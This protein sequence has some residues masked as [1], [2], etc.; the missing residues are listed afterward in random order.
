MTHP[1][2]ATPF[3]PEHAPMSILEDLWRRASATTPVPDASTLLAIASVALALVIVAW[4]QVRMLVTVCH[5]AGHAV[6]ATLTGRSIDG[7]R[8]HS[9]TSGVTLTRGRPTGVGMVVTL[10]G[11][12]P[13]AS[14]VGLLGAAIAG[15]GY[16]VGMLW[17]LVGLLVVMLLKI[18]NVH[19]ALVVLALAAVLALAS[20]YAPAHILVWLAYGLA[21]LLLLAGPRP[22]LELGLARR[23]ATT[24]SDAAQLARLTHVPRL[25]WIVVWLA[26]T[27]GA[28]AWGTVLMLPG[29]LPSVR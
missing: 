15:A 18:R 27:L 6:A 14:L 5:E 24:A 21:W 12:Y 9:D 26:G 16:A 3:T 19:G 28:L 8:L 10:L 7:I 11:G 22:V 1:S 2:P 17:L 4:S 20:W 25:V 29:L 13:A 23:Q